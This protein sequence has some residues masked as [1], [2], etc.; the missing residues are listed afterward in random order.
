VLLHHQRVCICARSAYCSV[1]VSLR[2]IAPSSLQITVLSDI[3]FAAACVCVAAVVAARAVD[4]PSGSSDGAAGVGSSDGAGGVDPVHA[5]ISPVRQEAATDSQSDVTAPSGVSATEI[6]A[7]GS[8]RGGAG[9]ATAEQNK[10]EQVFGPTM[11][12]A[13]RAHVEGLDT[14]SRRPS[15]GSSHE[16]ACSTPPLPP[17]APSSLLLRAASHTV[18]SPLQRKLEV[19]IVDDE[20][21]NLRFAARLV[22]KYDACRRRTVACYRVCFSCLCLCVSS[23]SSAL[24]LA[25]VGGR[26]CCA[27]G[28][29]SLV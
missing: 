22:N 16:S 5:I 15:V 4:V 21:L 23:A 19:L 6:R 14:G 26:R 18:M 8:S 17:R 24:D 25:C 27:G 7:A 12:S 10:P 9:A 20:P 29:G 28:T 11:A 3:A 2:C 13:L 1:A